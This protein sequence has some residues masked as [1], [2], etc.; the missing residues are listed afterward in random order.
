[1]YKTRMVLSGSLRLGLR[2]A[3]GCRFKPDR[4]IRVLYCESSI[5]TRASRPRWLGKEMISL[6][7]RVAGGSCPPPA[8]TERGVRISRTTL[9][10]HG[11]TAQRSSLSVYTGEKAWVA[12]TDTH[13]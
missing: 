11:L 8:P 5:F 9:F 10:R 3:R 4:Y 13:A 6:S 12:A 2:L 1:L 7:H